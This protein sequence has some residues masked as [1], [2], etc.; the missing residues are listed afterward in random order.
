[1]TTMLTFGA[2]GERNMQRHKDWPRQ[3]G[4]VIEK[5]WTLSDWAVAVSEESGELCGAIKRLNRMSAGHIIKR[6]DSAPMT[7]PEART[8]AIKEIGDII[9]YLD[10]MAQEGLGTTLEECVRLA[11]NGV[12]ERE[13]LPHR[14]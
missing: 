9:T 12:S 7:M 2:F 3:E 4:S 13:G 1:M 14:V 5:E 6:K 11:F 8:K 10:L